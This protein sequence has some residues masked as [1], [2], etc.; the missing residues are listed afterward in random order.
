M[1]K[2]STVNVLHTLTTFASICDDA[3][4]PLLEWI[5]GNSQH[6]LHRRLPPERE[7]HYSL[8]E[9]NH[10]YHQ[11]PERTTLLKDKNFIIRT[12]YKLRD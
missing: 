12:L 5:T 11:L 10:N 1:F 2:V 4:D 7:Q 8:C 6:L 3:D 9:R